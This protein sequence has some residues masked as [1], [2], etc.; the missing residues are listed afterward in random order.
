VK[1]S[2]DVPKELQRA[3]IRR[4][5]DNRNGCDVRLPD[6]ALFAIF[7]EE[8]RAR[9]LHQESSGDERAAATDGI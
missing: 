8:L 9:F 2:R 6:G 5:T 3:G 4:V 1:A 7:G